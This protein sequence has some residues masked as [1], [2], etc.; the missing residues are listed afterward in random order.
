MIILHY[1]LGF[2]PHRSGGLCRYSLDLIQA[3]KELGN[4]VTILYPGNFSLFSN[5]SHFKKEHAGI[6][7]LTNALP[8]PLLYGISTPSLFMSKRDIL[9]FDTFIEEIKPD[10]FHIHTLMGL[11]KELLILMKEAGIRIVYTSHDYFGLCPKVN[12]I[13]HKG[14]ICAGADGKRCEECCKGAH[15]KLFLKVRNSKYVTPLKKILR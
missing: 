3:E 5:K 1:I 7:Q 2:P 10:I 13:N 8:I 6:F 12:F 11:P 14:K 9:G 4:D 15:G